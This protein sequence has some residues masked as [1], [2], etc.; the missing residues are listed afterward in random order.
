M[1][2]HLLAILEKPEDSDFDSETEFPTVVSGFSEI[3]P[4]G[5]LV[6]QAKFKDKV[7]RPGSIRSARLAGD[8]EN[9]GF[10]PIEVTTQTTTT[11]P[12]VTQPL[13]EAS[14]GIQPTLGAIPRRQSQTKAPKTKKKAP[15]AP[16]TPFQGDLDFRDFYAED[17]NPAGSYY[18]PD[19][20]LGW[21]AQFERKLRE[22]FPRAPPPDPPINPDFARTGPPPYDQSMAEGWGDGLG[23]NGFSNLDNQA[24]LVGQNPNLQ[25]QSGDGLSN[26]ENQAGIVGQNPN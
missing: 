8:S 15:K 1:D 22:L 17:Q 6:N 18:T 2:Y 10:I 24:G 23:G 7:F 25:Q 14:G 13:T 11:N 12:T 3:Q 26:L 16:T 5:D 21:T 9:R 4:K 20:S 19:R